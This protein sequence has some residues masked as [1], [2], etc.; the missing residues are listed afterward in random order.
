[1]YTR[2]SS[3]TATD[4]MKAKRLSNGNVDSINEWF[5]ILNLA[6]FGLLTKT[7]SASNYNRGAQILIF[8]KKS[9]QEICA[10]VS[11]KCRFN[12][13]RIDKELYINS[14]H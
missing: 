2:G 7:I 10:D 12:L 1:M 8:K 14:F 5:E 6:G 11:T 13:F 3:F 9:L 4:L